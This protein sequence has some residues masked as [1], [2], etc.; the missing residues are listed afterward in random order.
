MIFDK[1]DEN[2]DRWYETPVG[3]AVD[4]MEKRAFL[5]VLELK[6]GERLLSVRKDLCID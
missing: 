3:V 6:V 4:R 1:I 5:K 2:Y